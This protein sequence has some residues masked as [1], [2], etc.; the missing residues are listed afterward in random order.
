VSAQQSRLVGAVLAEQQD[1]WAE[2]RSYLGFDDV[3]CKS[4]YDQT[5]AIRTGCPPGG[6][7]RLNHPIEESRDY[8]VHH[9]H[10][11]DPR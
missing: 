4:R 11:L 5:P 9:A 6:T 1:E 3:L 10:R 7:D 2:S 8:V